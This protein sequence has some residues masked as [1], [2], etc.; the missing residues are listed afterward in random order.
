MLSDPDYWLQTGEAELEWAIKQEVRKSEARN[1]ILFLG[2]GMGVSTVTAARI[3]KGQMQGHPGEEEKLSFERLPNV[4]ML[5]V[6]ELMVA[7]FEAHIF[8]IKLID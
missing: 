3:L 8:N 6:G 5:K 2:D 4:A 7:L 1:V